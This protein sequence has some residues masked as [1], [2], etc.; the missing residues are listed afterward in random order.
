M[1]ADAIWTLVAF[2]LTVMVLSYALGDNPLFRIA[3]YLFIG[4][5]AGYVAVLIIYQVLIAKLVTPMISGAWEQKLLGLIPLLLG[6]LLI[7]KLFP[8]LAPIG[9]VPMAFL[10][11]V[12]AAIAIGG[13]LTGTLFGQIRGALR[14]FDITAANGDVLAQLAGGTVLLFG[15]V[16]SLA[17]FHFGARNRGEQIVQRPALIE[18]AAKIGQV[19]IAITLGAL[20]AGVLTAALTALIERLHFIILFFQSLF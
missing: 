19:F 15:T 6:F 2:F 1:Q 12:G 8:R 16:T 9:N 18:T 4:V 20:F 14:P 10:V 17:Y 11:G 3:S 13:A 7:F 5:S